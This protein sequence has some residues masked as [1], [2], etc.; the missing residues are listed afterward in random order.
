MNF[1]GVE[2][3]KGKDEPDADFSVTYLAK[4]YDKEKN[5]QHRVCYYDST[6]GRSFVYNDEGKYMYQMEYNKDDF[7]KIVACLKA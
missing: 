5:I 4:F 2:Q 6:I 3:S 7:G 1:N